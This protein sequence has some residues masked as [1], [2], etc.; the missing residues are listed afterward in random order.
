MNKS[1]NFAGTYSGM[2]SECIDCD[3]SPESIL[4]D[5]RAAAEKAEARL[6]RIYPGEKANRREISLSLIELQMVID[7]TW[8]KEPTI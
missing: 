6:N 7:R 3:L 1:H 2:S 5:I 4:N 8:C